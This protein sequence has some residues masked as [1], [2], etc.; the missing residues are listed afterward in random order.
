MKWIDRGF[1]P[2]PIEF[3]RLVQA[4]VDDPDVQ[5][6][7]AGL[8]A[9][10]RAGKELDDGPRDPVLSEF[11]EAELLRLD[12]TSANR[13]DPAPSPDKI[14][15]LFLATLTEMWGSIIPA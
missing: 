2:V 6:A 10:K 11:V 1:G 8:L 13:T 7:I 12:D 14:D 4:T 5:E 3:D 9:A 15:S